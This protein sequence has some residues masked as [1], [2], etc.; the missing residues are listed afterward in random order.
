[1]QGVG[2]TYKYNWNELKVEFLKGDWLSVEA[3]LR[4]KNIPGDNHGSTKGWG[5]EKQS[6]GKKMVEIATQEIVDEGINE[7]KKVRERQATIA[8]KLQFKGLE[9]IDKMSPTNIEEARKLI[10]TGLIQERDALGIGESKKGGVT[11]LTQV[12]VNLPKTKLDQLLDG[13][14]AE[15]ILKIIAELR[16]QRKLRAGAV[17]DIQSEGEVVD[18]GTG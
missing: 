7:E 1:M 15:G 16:R 4:D 18:Q 14:D 9:T 6:L 8:R 13:L 10:Q 17:S 11:S 2:K 3:F 12:N 5:A